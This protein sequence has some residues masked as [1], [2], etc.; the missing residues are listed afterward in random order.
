MPRTKDANGFNIIDENNKC[1]KVHH[2]AENSKW[3]FFFDHL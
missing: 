3:S 1:Q 2:I